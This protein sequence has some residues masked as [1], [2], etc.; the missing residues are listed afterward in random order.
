[1]RDVPC[2]VNS[3]ESTRNAAIEKIKKASEGDD[4]LESVAEELDPKK[5]REREKNCQAIRMIVDKC[6]ENYRDGEYSFKESVDML[7]GAFKK[8]K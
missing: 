7:C 5:Q 3:Y 1:M 2:S 8:L 6:L 4:L